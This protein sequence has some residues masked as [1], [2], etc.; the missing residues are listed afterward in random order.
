MAGLILYSVVVIPYRICFDQP[1]EGLMQVLDHLVDVMFALDI[2]INF[3][4]AYFDGSGTVLITVPRLIAAQCASASEG[5][6]VPI[7][8][9][10]STT[11]TPPPSSIQTCAPGSW[12][13]C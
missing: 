10:S 1:A 11:T 3:R 7:P 12:S 5:R 4:T 8:I 13:T 6:L 9:T 2:V